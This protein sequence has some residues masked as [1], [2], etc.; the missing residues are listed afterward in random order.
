[1]EV[2]IAVK[3]RSVL[4]KHRS[5]SAVVI[6]SVANNCR[7]SDILGNMLQWSS[8]ESAVRGRFSDGC[9]CHLRRHSSYSDLIATI[10]SANMNMML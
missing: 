6:G 1:M 8:A 4:E 3:V 5:A 7:R 2:R 10:G 9:D